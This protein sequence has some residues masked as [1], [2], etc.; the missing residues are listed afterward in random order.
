MVANSLI[1][2]FGANGSGIKAEFRSLDFKQQLKANCQQ[3]WKMWAVGTLLY[4]VKICIDGKSP[5]SEY[6]NIHPPTLNQY[7]K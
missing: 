5:V 6:F 2:P 7:L 1:R 3:V 4:N